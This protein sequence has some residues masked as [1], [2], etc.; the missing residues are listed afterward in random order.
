MELC[1]GGSQGLLGPMCQW[2][3]HPT[4]PY[5][6]APVHTREISKLEDADISVLWPQASEE[7]MHA[8]PPNLQP[9]NIATNVWWFI[10]NND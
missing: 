5:P 3:W 6:F 8:I 2:V 7:I 9:Y 10:A 1:L 4:W